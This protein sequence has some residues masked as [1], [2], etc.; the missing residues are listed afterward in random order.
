MKSNISR[1]SKELSYFL[2]SRV[3][4]ARLLVAGSGIILVIF[5]GRVYG[6]EVLGMFTIAQA[7]IISITVFSRG[8]LDFALTKLIAISDLEKNAHQCFNWAF[9]RVLILSVSLSFLLFFLSYFIAGL[10]DSPELFDWLRIAALASVPFSLI[11]VFAGYLKGL[12]FPFSASFFEN[13]AVCLLALAG[14]FPFWFFEVKISG[15]TMMIL[16]CLCAWLLLAIAMWY[17]KLPFLDNITRP[18]YIEPSSPHISELA[19]ISKSTLPISFAAYIQSSVLLLYCGY[20]LS[21]ADLG[22]LRAS[23]QVGFAISFL[24][25][26]AN[27]ILPAK[28][29]QFYNEGNLSY[30]SS[31]VRKIILFSLLLVTLPV[32]ICMI[33]PE[34]ILGWFGPDFVSG[35]PLLRLILIGHFVNVTLGSLNALLVMTGHQKEMRNIAIVSSLLGFL[36]CVFSVNLF[37]AIG[38][39]ASIVF[40]LILQNLACFFSVRKLLGFWPLLKY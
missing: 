5:F 15:I 34:W 40:V 4:A 12:Q 37:G 6:V 26:V 11:A 13:N 27:A 29:A 17:V 1:D 28:F 19:E 31:F 32:V 38:A 14:I 7:F 36:V 23:Q 9:K 8:G 3:A 2:F 30:L 20:V 22:I 18:F 24:L 39:A 25:M 16:F 10:Y 35:A 33:F 21:N